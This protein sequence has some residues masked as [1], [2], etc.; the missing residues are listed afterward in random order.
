M[1][2]SKDGRVVIIDDKYNE[3][4]PLLKILSRKGIPCIHITGEKDSLPNEDVLLSPRII[5]LDLNLSFVKDAKNVISQLK[6]ILDRIIS[7]PGN[8]YIL[9]IWSKKG[10]DYLTELEILFRDILPNKK[11]LQQINLNKSDY[12]KLNPTSQ[13]YDPEDDAETKIFEKL[14]EVWKELDA[15]KYLLQWENITY[16]SISEISNMIYD[17]TVDDKDRNKSLKQLYYKIAEAYWGKQI[18]ADSYAKPSAMILNNIFTGVNEI[19]LFEKLN[20]E[21]LNPTVY[22]QEITDDKTAAINT[23]LLT[24]KSF[25]DKVIPGSIYYFEK[26]EILNC[27]MMEAIDRSTFLEDYCN[28][29]HLNKS[30]VSDENSRIKEAHKKAF[31]KYAYKKIPEIELRSKYIEIEIS[32]ICDFSQN[33]QLNFK[34]LS[35]MLVKAVDMKYLKKNADFLYKTPKIKFDKDIYHFVFDLRLI[36]T[37][38]KVSLQAQAFT[39]LRQTILNEIQF[40]IGKHL[41]RIGVTYITNE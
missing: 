38:T 34:T 25:L 19:N 3:I 12:F 33:R 11:P 21:V 39:R 6:P 4:L 15:I 20:P 37:L 14:D 7:N 26:P 41:S 8:P 2:F 1:N 30:D 22:P 24:S 17:L 27:L 16:D 31:K 35:G 40:N 10:G 36:N 9:F 29:N 28:D 5:F 18:K 23:Q 32:P 13:E